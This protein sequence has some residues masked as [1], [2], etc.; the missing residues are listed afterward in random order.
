MLNALSC[1]THAHPPRVLTRCMHTSR[2]PHCMIRTHLVRLRLGLRI[3]IR[4]K[5]RVRARVRVRLGLRLRLQG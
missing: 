5:D 4:V 1:P 3:R 2:A